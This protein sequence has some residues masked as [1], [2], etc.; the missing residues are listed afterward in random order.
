MWPGIQVQLFWV[1]CKA[2]S[3]LC[4]SILRTNQW[5]WSVRKYESTL[6]ESTL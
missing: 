1:V 3:L 5:Y 6:K 2:L 4:K